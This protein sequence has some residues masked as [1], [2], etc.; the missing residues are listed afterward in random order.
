MT[1]FKLKFGLSI[2]FVTNYST[3]FMD[4]KTGNILSV[5]VIKETK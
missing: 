2:I 1:E 3:F 4:A 5:E